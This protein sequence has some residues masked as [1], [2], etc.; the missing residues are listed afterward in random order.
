MIELAYTP[1]PLR[2]RI[3]AA[4]PFAPEQL[5]QW[6]GDRATSG[7]VSFIWSADKQHGNLIF[8]VPRNPQMDEPIQREKSLL[9]YLH[10]HLGQTPAYNQ[11]FPHVYGSRPLGRG[12]ALLL[13]PIPGQPLADFLHRW[14]RTYYLHKA[15]QW[16]SGWQQHMVQ[17]W[18]VLDRERLAWLLTSYP[19]ALWGK[20]SIPELLPLPEE[21]N[22][23]KKGVWELM[24]PLLGQKLPLTIVHGAFQADNIWVRRGRI[25]GLQH[26]EDGRTEGLPWEDFWQLPL[27]LYRDKS[28]A[29]AQ[30]WKHLITNRE[31]IQAYWHTYQQSSDMAQQ[32]RPPWLWLPW[33]C[34]IEAIKQIL[35][36]RRD[37][38]QYQYWLEM[39][40][41]ALNQ[42]YLYK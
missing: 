14:N 18:I 30:S 19:D 42:P 20:C 39:A 25:T 24:R 4:P 10:Q 31:I 35:P 22:E 37:W 15:G 5:L 41:Y 16:L 7:I 23:V 26:W 34:L 11:P 28:G 29:A 32:L 33:V 2:E 38:E 13:T 12:Q 1:V 36:W 9:H 40:R 6:A 17:K 21:L 8:R 3:A 27:A